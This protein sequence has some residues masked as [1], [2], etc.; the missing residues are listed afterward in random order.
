MFRILF[1]VL[2]PFSI[3]FLI[4]AVK[5]RFVKTADTYP[6][7]TLTAAGLGCVFAFLF[8]FSEPEKAPADSVYTPPK[9]VNGQIVPAH[10]DQASDA[11][12]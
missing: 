3:P 11:S 8:F 1:S 12:E 10:M 2:L 5:R 7:K 6:L 9:F 4:Y